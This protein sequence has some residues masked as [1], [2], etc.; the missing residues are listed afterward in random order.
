VDLFPKG[1]MSSRRDESSFRRRKVKRLK[2]PPDERYNYVYHS[3]D[4]YDDGWWWFFFIIFGFF[5]LLIIIAAI[6]G[7][8]GNSHFYDDDDDDTSTFVRE[9]ERGIEEDPT[10]N[11]KSE[12]FKILKNSLKERGKVNRKSDNT[13]DICPKGTIPASGGYVLI[14]SSD[15]IPNYTSPVAI[16]ETII[17][18]GV[19]PCESFSEFA[20][21]GWKGSGGRSFTYSSN[22]NKKVLR[23]VENLDAIGD[24]LNWGQDEYIENRG[25]QISESVSAE[26]DIFSTF[27]QECHSSINAIPDSLD[28]VNSHWLLD[29][30][31][32]M[33]ESQK[34]D[35]GSLGS[36]FGIS[37][38]MGSNP[39][40]HIRTETDLFDNSKPLFYIQPKGFVGM[41]SNIRKRHLY[42]MDSCTHLLNKY[43]KE[44][45][46]EDKITRDICAQK[47]KEID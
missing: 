44:S 34:E 11:K 25:G 30:L 46:G 31:I 5:I 16:D 17:N 20:C 23:M 6:S 8:H 45:S 29:R 14:S 43:T 37:T 1:K 32:G 24:K 9:I 13:D 15:C 18:R 2:N 26:R 10:D 28:D 41:E 40:F 27:V 47:I 4:S 36:L 42:V 35:W 33:I 38:C 12:A 21:S 7:I 39:L 19:S 3:Y 22:S